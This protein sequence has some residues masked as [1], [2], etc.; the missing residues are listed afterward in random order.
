M[1]ESRLGKESVRVRCA[2]WAR[3]VSRSFGGGGEVGVGPVG[4]AEAASRP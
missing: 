2:A 1:W 3:A 4:F